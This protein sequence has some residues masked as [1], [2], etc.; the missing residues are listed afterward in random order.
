MLLVKADLRA[1]C[2]VVLAFVVV[3]LKGKC[4]KRPRKVFLPAVI[5][6][7]ALILGVC[8]ARGAATQ[9][10]PPT[11]FIPQGATVTFDAASSHIAKAQRVGVPVWLA[12]DGSSVTGETCRL[13]FAVP[14][15]SRTDYQPVILNWGGVETNRV[16]VYQ[17]TP[18]LRPLSQFSP[19]R[20]QAHFGIGEFVTL[21]FTTAPPVSVEEIGGLRWMMDEA[22]IPLWDGADDGVAMTQVLN[23]T[24][25][26]KLV[27][28]GGPGRGFS[29]SSSSVRFRQVNEQGIPYFGAM[30]SN[31][32]P[33][34]AHAVGMDASKK[35]PYTNEVALINALTESGDMRGLE[36]LVLEAKASA[37]SDTNRYFDLAALIVHALGTYEFDLARQFE[38]EQTVARELLAWPGLPLG[39]RLFLL[40]QMRTDL[41]S[42]VGNP[43]WSATRKRKA[44]QFCRAWQECHAAV[45]G[46]YDPADMKNS[47]TWGNSLPKEVEVENRRRAEVRDQYEQAKSRLEELA[48]MAERYLIRAY[49]RPPNATA[50][51]T[52]LLASYVPEIAARRR[53]QDAVAQRTSR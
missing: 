37:A 45:D 29:V 41:P 30:I 10:F 51:L 15:R 20:D 48:P 44:E 22:P 5:W 13:S 17:V 6:G 39:R 3:M 11:L 26:V 18:Q 9:I 42:D 36:A 47:I 49:S 2:F 24:G 46:K 33:G 52:Q 23:E 43:S 38:L 7:C 34:R 4:M 12:P 35:L 1:S 32:R 28:L 21:S 50:E 19:D 40:G 31:P 16:I 27:I 14:S 53:I 25:A 8:Y